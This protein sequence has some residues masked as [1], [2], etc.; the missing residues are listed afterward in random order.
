[1]TKLG[2]ILWQCTGILIF[3]DATKLHV[4]R[5]FSLGSVFPPAKN[6][7]TS[8]ENVMTC[9]TYRV[10][11]KQL[12]YLPGSNCAHS[13]KF[14]SVGTALLYCVFLRFCYFSWQEDGEST[15]DAKVNPKPLFTFHRLCL[16]ARK[17]A[18]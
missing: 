17:I 13:N 8:S 6:I 2:R 7:K 1:M 16:R 18:V 12:L 5:K 9:G 15:Q 3:K 4:T 10:H 14:Y 11:S